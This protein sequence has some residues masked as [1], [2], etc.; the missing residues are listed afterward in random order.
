MTKRA[1]QENRQNRLET[2]LEKGRREKQLNEPEVLALF[3]DPESQEA[4]D[5]LDQLEADGIEIIAEDDTEID[6][7]DIEDELDDGDDDDP[8]DEASEPTLPAGAISD[9]PVRM[10]LKEIGQ[11][12]LLNQDRETWLAAQLAAVNR[13]RELRE[14]L[15]IENGV[16]PTHLEIF[17]AM[18]DEALEY[19]KHVNKIAD[20]N[21]VKLP[22]L[23]CVIDEARQLR[24]TWHGDVASYVRQYLLQGNWGRDE[25]W[26]SLA[27]ALLQIFHVFYLAPFK[28]QDFLLDYYKKH[29]DLPDFTIALQAYSD[30]PSELEARLIDGLNDAV[31]RSNEAAEAL[32]RANLRLVVSVAKRYMG[33]GISFLDLIQEGNIGL[34]RAVEKFD[35]TKGFKFSTYATWWILQAIRRAIADQART[36]RI[37]VHMVET[38]NRL[39]RVQRDLT[40]EKG[41][42]PTAEDLALEMQFL[43]EEEIQRVKAIQEAEQELEQIDPMLYRKLRREANKIRRILRISQEPM[44]LDMTV[45]Q[46]DS[47]I[48][49]DFIEDDKMPGPVDA[50]TGQLLKEQIRDALYVLNEREREVLEMRFGLKDGQE[51]T[52]EEVGKYYGVTRERIRQIEAKAL[53]KLRQPNRSRPLRDYLE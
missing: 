17:R 3:D 24:Q 10:Y 8:L 16:S 45:G 18:Y 31:F 11:V 14:D 1:T 49:G 33:R 4:L 21:R 53:R 42:E 36:I 9:D 46:E 22:E 30:D 12:E 41:A 7:V 28:L 25:T 52:L 6:D 20:R 19:W 47:S 38:I 13:F 34:L 51:H 43:E 48:L 50:A 35:H 32:T 27:H 37:P 2:L 44:S 23:D 5:F 29:D 40:Q 26:T 39:M 15:K